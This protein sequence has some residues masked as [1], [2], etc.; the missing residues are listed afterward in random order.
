MAKAVKFK[1]DYYLDSSNV[2]SNKNNLKNI[3]DSILSNPIGEFVL[4][5]GEKEIIENGDW[6]YLGEYYWLKQK[7]ES[8]FPIDDG[9]KR[10]MKLCIESTDNLQSGMFEYIKL[11]Q[12]ATYS[13]EYLFPNVHGGVSDGIRTFQWLDFDY[14]NLPNGHISIE[15][16]P[17]FEAG[18]STIRIYKLYLLIYDTI[19]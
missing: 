4:W 18:G 2:N 9:F 12:G 16:T 15:I 17:S 6:Q 7:I 5:E 1:N 11:T 3:V 10:K 8:K 19:E 13:K 14:D